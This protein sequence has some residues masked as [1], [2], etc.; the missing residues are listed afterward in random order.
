MS[1]IKIV[2]DSSAGLT[3]EEIKKYN[4]TIVPLS[5]MIDGTVYVERE[6]ITNDQFPAMMK[7]A[8]SLPKTSQ[9][10]IGKFVDA[11]DKLGE[12][13]SEVLCVTM[14][15][16]ISG[17]VHAAE[18]AAGMTKTKVTVYDSQTTDQGMAFQIVEAAKVIEDGGSVEDA[19][20]KMKD[21][22]AK[23]KLYLA[24]DNLDNLVAGGRISK[25]AGAVSNLLNIKVMLQVYGGQI[26]IE[27][28]GRGLK[29]IHKEWGKILDEMARGPK[30]KRIGISHVD[31]GKE[32]DRLLANLKELYPNINVVVRETVPIIA[33]HTGMGACCLLYYTE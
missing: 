3:D 9:P 13:G 27:A 23:S 21:V 22:L 5:V 32:V 6:T 30:V 7:N 8:N 29:S 15:E 25:F 33:T 28:K 18:Q 16:S 31:A 14:M 17:T 10:P 20:S 2:C 4:I 12:D 24:I 26:H 19:I 1:K 11:F